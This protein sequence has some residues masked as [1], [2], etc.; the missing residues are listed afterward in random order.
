MT[1]ELC[2]T[3]IS[4]GCLLSL[5]QIE[6]DKQDAVAYQL[7]VRLLSCTDRFVEKTRTSNS[8][9]PAGVNRLSSFRDTNP[10]YERGFRSFAVVD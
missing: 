3:R 6:E 7:S 1:A 2:R 5:P 8:C 4:V 9:V 10:L